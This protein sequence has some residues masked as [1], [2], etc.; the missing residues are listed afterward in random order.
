MRMVPE[1]WGTGNWMAR[2]LPH[3]YQG[4]MTMKKKVPT[5]KSGSGDS[6]SLDSCSRMSDPSAFY[7]LLAMDSL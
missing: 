4:A 7:Y 2:K 5:K 3:R 6:L 1:A